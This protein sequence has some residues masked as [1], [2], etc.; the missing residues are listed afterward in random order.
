MI[1]SLADRTFQLRWALLSPADGRALGLLVVD[2][3]AALLV[4]AAAARLLRTKLAP[5]ES[6]A[7]DACGA[8]DLLDALVE[9]D[10]EDD[11]L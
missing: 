10:P 5:L 8:G 11:G 2:A 1:R 9:A 7:D 3:A 4:Q 6:A